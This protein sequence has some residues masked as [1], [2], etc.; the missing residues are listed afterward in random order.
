MI[1]QLIFLWWLSTAAYCSILLP[2]CPGRCASS[3]GASALGPGY[4]AQP[5]PVWFCRFRYFNHYPGFLLG[6]WGVADCSPSW[7]SL[8]AVLSMLFILFEPWPLEAPISLQHHWLVAAWDITQAKK[9]DMGRSNARVNVGWATLRVILWICLAKN[10]A[11]TCFFT[12]WQPH[13][14]KI[15][16]S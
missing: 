16:N 1:F 9:A 13:I 5:R 12:T 6:R 7:S 15:S 10:A 2:G 3:H 11:W 4:W 8:L 14:A